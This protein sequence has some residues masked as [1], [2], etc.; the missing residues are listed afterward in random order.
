MPSSS[1]L[2]LDSALLLLLIGAHSAST[3]V[4][5]AQIDSTSRSLE[6][7]EPFRAN[8]KP[9]LSME[10]SVG[11]IEVDGELDEPAWD[12]A[13]RAVNFSESW[14]DERARPPIDIEVRATYDDSNLYLAYVIGDDP[15]AVRANFSDRD[16]IWQDDY[17]G[18]LLDTNG[19]GAQT[20]FI[21]ANAIGIQGDT[22]ITPNNEDVSFNLVFQSQGKLTDSGYQVEFA[23]PFRS[24]RFP[25]SESQEWKATFW[26]THPREDRNTYSWAGIDRN[27]PCFT[28]QYG[29]IRGISGV[30]SGGNLELL[31][32]LTG[33]QSAGLVDE[34]DP[35][36][37]FEQQKVDLRPSLDL[38]YGITSNHILDLTLNPDFSQIEADAAQVDVN[39]TFALFFPERRPFF[40]EGSDLFDTDI[41]LVY[42]RSINDPIAAGKVTSRVGRLD[43][44]YIG[45]RD[46]AS[47]I[48][49]P[50]EERSEVVSDAG[51]SVTNIVRA[52]FNFPDQSFIGGLVTDRRLD[53]GGSGSTFAF[54]GAVRFF[55]QYRLS[56]QFA[57]SYTVEPKDSTL[58]EAF[59]GSTF[60]GGRHTTDFDGE[61]FW[62][63]STEVELNR[64]SRYWN[65]EIEYAGASQTF[66]ADNGFVRQNATRRFEM[67]QGVTTYP[68][69]GFINRIGPFVNLGRNW[70]WDGVRK[71]EWIAPGFWTSLVGQTNLQVWYMFGNE[72]FN[73]VDFTGLR[74]LNVR[75]HSNFSELAQVGF[76]LNYGRDIW[77]NDDEPDIGRMLDVEIDGQLRPTQRLRLR[78]LFSFSRLR[79]L[80]TEEDF[81]NGYIVRLRA[82]YQFT[83]KFFFRLVGQYNQFSDRLEVDPLLTYRINPFSAFFIGSTHDVVSFPGSAPDQPRILQQTSRQVFFK[84]QYQFRT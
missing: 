64:D 40:Q 53:A 48:L 25:E 24:L 68:S 11:P 42:T 61:R 45:G 52:R 33:G 84:F 16:Q 37:Q 59:N 63:H 69:V 81:F 32:S 18:I 12:A 77:R 62:G 73:G 21:A 34:E 67:F 83:R 82:D 30:R 13:E 65:F 14:P 75:L 38:K 80:E 28:C 5:E 55:K 7:A 71:E 15:G 23:I 56:G 6:L 60:A 29:T 26:I 9:L 50:F 27:D 57:G 51:K 66:R 19:D 47:P 36:S 78:P 4:A 58:S 2:A 70:N 79:D 31:P 49:V 35:N 22:K 41:N 44:G 46:N 72:R 43:V 74:R 20:Y 54:D 39:S 8:E 10:R 76:G 1:R 17:V 3:A